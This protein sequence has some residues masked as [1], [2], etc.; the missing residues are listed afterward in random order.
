MP[1]IK[2][3]K[4]CDK[5]KIS[6]PYPPSYRSNPGPDHSTDSLPTEVQD[7]Q[8]MRSS[9]QPLLLNDTNRSRSP[10][11]PTVPLTAGLGNKEHSNSNPGISSSTM[12]AV[13]RV[14]QD[15]IELP[16]GWSKEDEEAEREFMRKGLFDWKAL[17][18]WRYWIRKEWWGESSSIEA[19]MICVSS[20][21]DT[22][23]YLA[24]IVLAVLV[25]LMT[26]FHDQVCR[27]HFCVPEP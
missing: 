22:G 19:W 17:M 13:A 8:Y 25:A 26:I 3:R 14:D 20:A 12:S 27:S 11:D 24:A 18:G 4:E 21:D 9:P 16:A 7:G 15:G 10:S 2:S 6:H 23:W 5:L 1:L